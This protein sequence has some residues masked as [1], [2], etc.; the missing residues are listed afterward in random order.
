MHIYSQLWSLFKYFDTDGAN[1][2]TRDNIIEAF[3]RLGRHISKKKFKECIYLK[4]CNSYLE[5]PVNKIDEMIHEIDPNHDGKISF[6]EFC[7]MMGD[8]G[9]EKSINITD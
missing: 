9:I 2:I 6:E 5:L 8:Q 7:D 3:A 1:Y 4:V